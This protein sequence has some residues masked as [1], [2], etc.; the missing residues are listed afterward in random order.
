M[1]KNLLGVLAVCGVV[2]ILSGCA[3]VLGAFGLSGRAQTV[4]A[5]AGLVDFRA[6][7]QL[8]STTSTADVTQNNF[9]AAKILTPP[10]AATANQAE[11]LF[12]NGNR[13]WARTVLD[14]YKPKNEDLF[15]GRWVLYMYNYSHRDQVTQDNYRRARWDFARV[16]SVDEL[17]RGRVELGGRSVYVKWTRVTDEVFD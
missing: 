15:V 11:V 14:T 4:T 3:T 12:A 2:V 17:F 16:T 6:D 1:K 5:R 13:N 10:S 8:V 7:E 9:S